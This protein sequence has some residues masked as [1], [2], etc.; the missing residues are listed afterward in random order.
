MARHIIPA[1]PP[2]IETAFEKRFCWSED[3]NFTA[4]GRRIGLSTLN[5]RKRD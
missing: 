3:G 5:K 4:F 1:A 2:R